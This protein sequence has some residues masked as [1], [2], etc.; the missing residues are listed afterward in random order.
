MRALE[1]PRRLSALPDPRTL[2][3]ELLAGL[4]VALVLILSGQM[5]PEHT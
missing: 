1:V 4:V 5:T 2:R 3:V